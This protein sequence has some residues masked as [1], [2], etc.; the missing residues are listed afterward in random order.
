MPSTIRI[1]K[2]R[3]VDA[4]MH[5][6]HEGEGVKLYREAT[7]FTRQHE[8]AVAEAMQCV[9]QGQE[10]LVFTWRPVGI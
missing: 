4:I 3:G 2:L 9:Q 7:L 10:E 5:R 1:E 6:I 8:L